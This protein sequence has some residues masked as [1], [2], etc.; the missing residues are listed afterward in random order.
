[1][2][3]P[4]ATNKEGICYAFPDVCN[5]PVGS[6]DVPVPYPNIGKLNEVEGSPMDEKKNVKVTGHFVITDKCCIKRTTGDEAGT[7]SNFH[8]GSGPHGKVTF[9]KFSKSVKVN[10][11]FVVRLTDKTAQNDGNAEGMVLNGEPTVLCG[12]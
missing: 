4:I 9:V 10:D 7:S 11:G 3:L 6:S 1:M 2:G 12:D 5:T 8:E